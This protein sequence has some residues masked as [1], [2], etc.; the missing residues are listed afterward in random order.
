MEL[1]NLLGFCNSLVIFADFRSGLVRKISISSCISEMKA[2]SNPEIIE[3]II[4]NII[5]STTIT[6]SNT[7]KILE[8]S[9]KKI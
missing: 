7:E 5:M 3:L 9:A 1:N 4:N 8:D 6:I 2:T